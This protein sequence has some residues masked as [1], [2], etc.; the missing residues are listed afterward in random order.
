M[1]KDDD[2]REMMAGRGLVLAL[3]CVAAL[4]GLPLSA[5]DTADPTGGIRGPVVGAPV[6]PFVFDGDVRDLPR[7]RPWRPGDPIRVIPQ[8]HYRAPGQAPPPAGTPVF[9]PLLELQRVTSLDADLL[10]DGFTIP[11]RNFPGIGFTGSAPPDTVGDVGPNH[12]IQMV[13]VAG[14]ALVQIWDKAAPVPTLLATFDTADLAPEVCHN[15][16]D[17]VVLYDRGADRWVL[18]HAG[19][20]GMCFF[21]SRTPDPVSGGWY[22][23]SLPALS[24]DYPKPAVWPTDANHGAGSYV[25]T[26]NYWTEPGIHAY[27][28]GAML[29]GQAANSVSFTVSLLSGFVVQAP[30]PADTDGPLTPPAGALAVFMRHRDTEIH[31]GPTAPGDLLDMWL[32]DVNWQDPGSA[33]LTQAASIDVADFDSTTCNLDF[34]GCFPQP[35]S[36]DALFPLSELI[37]HRLQYYNHGDFE[38]LL[39]NFVVDVDGW[40]HGG[41][42]WFELRRSSGEDWALYQEGTYSIDDHHRWMGSIA[43]DQSGNIA[44][45]Y[46]VVSETLY[47]A[48]RYTGRMRDDCPGMMTQPEIE[49]DASSTANGIERWGD[50]AAMSLDPND[51]C[52]FWFTGENVNEDRWW[53]TQIASFRF[54]DCGCDPV[55]LPVLLAEAGGDN[56]IDILWEDS[57]SEHV[58]QYIVR[59]AFTTGGPFETLAVVED[60]SPGLAGGPGYLYEDIGV[61]GGVT[62]YY[63]V[64]AREES[65][66]RSRPFNEVSAV[67]GGT[68]FVPPLFDGLRSAGFEPSELCHVDLAWD[69]ATP[70]CGGPAAYNVYRSAL[71][72]FEP[73]PE[74]L[75]VTGLSQ[76]TLR[77]VEALEPNVTQYYVVRAVDLANQAE[78][79]NVIERYATPTGPDSGEFTWLWEDFEAEGS[80]DAWTVVNG[81]DHEC[82]EWEL[83]CYVAEDDCYPVADSVGCPADEELTSTN[84]VSP[85]FDLSDPTVAEAKLDFWSTIDPSSDDVRTVEAW[86][87]ST[88]QLAVDW[89]TVFPKL[90]FDMTPWAA[91]NPDF[92][93]RFHFEDT[94]RHGS[95]GVDWI[96]LSV[97]V[98]D[99]CTSGPSAP[100]VMISAPEDGSSFAVG[101]EVLFAASASDP[102]DGDLSDGLVWTSSLDGSIGSGASFSFSGLATGNHTILAEVT[103]SDLLTGADSV[104]I[105]VVVIEP[106]SR[107]RAIASRKAPS[108][109]LRW[110]DNS[111]N[112]T[113]FEIERSLDPVSGFT[114]LD[115]AGPD[116]R[117]YTDTGLEEQTTY[118]YRIRACLDQACS[119]WS[120]VA[121]AT[122]Y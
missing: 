11:S 98:A 57:A 9:D 14:G 22:A 117:T 61:S 64:V 78:D 49:F 16:F 18:A 68:C 87:G 102:E 6:T 80:F 2:D 94:D 121:D 106:P 42:R 114:P 93:F 116:S 115:Q 41:I 75:L 40:D 38:S 88:W 105:R 44:L 77:D 13:N 32:L 86:D 27:D 3:T 100:T 47:P 89:T 19:D 46:S 29:S 25:A 59:R 37:M 81:P 83:E 52:T 48:L 8:R 20:I 67:T 122:T 65:G 101:S 104:T 53:R 73:G 111:D 24:A 35:D 33:T 5:G 36:D 62:Y 109:T 72:G 92:R 66:C 30:T 55:P 103:D 95:W 12:Y 17:P 45:G 7:P 97:R 23:Y 90:P 28:R 15:G 96:E 118:Y 50:Y 1:R 108:I 60:T 120:D 69:P 43:M 31:D 84:L 63:V 110:E 76:T 71:R 119:T 54:E 85:S 70:L 79:A 113:A 56:Q 99:S 34:R 82:G 4:I 10:V 91:G 39:G 51:D 58:V 74:N 112:E 26:T 107:L 21:I